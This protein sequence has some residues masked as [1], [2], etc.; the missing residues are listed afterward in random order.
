MILFAMRHKY[1][2]VG[3]VLSRAPLGEANTL[4]TLLTPDLGVVRARAQGLRRPGAKLSSSLPTLAEAEATL[5]RGK[6]EWR[7]SGAVLRENWFL[8]LRQFA[9]RARAARVGGLLLRLAGQETND[10]ALFPI[11]RDFLK[12]LTDRPE[13]EHEGAE[14]LAVLHLLQTLGLDTGEPSPFASEALTSIA[15]NRADYI[16]RINRGIEASGL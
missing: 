7:L 14:I 11:F 9:P 12:A 13:G 1:D 16:A 15:G 5:V 8:A 2:T 6:G 3:I 4:V 10:H